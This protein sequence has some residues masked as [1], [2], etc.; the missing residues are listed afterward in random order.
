MG[1]SA[2]TGD[3]TDA[4]PLPGGSDSDD[5]SPP[6]SPPSDSDE[7]APDIEDLAD[8]NTIPPVSRSLAPGMLGDSFFTRGQILGMTPSSHGGFIDIPGSRRAKITENNSPL[9]RDR[10]YFMYQHF[11]NAIRGA[12]DFEEWVPEQNERQFDFSANR[13]VIG[14]EKTFFKGCCSAEIRIPLQDSTNFGVSPWP[15]PY[16]L[17]TARSDSGSLGNISLTFKGL[18]RQTNKGA[19][20]AG[21][22]VDLPT[23]PSASGATYWQPYELQ[24]DSVHLGPFL[25]AIYR[26]DDCW[27]FQGFMQLDVDVNGSPFEVTD[28]WTGAP[29]RMGVLQDQTLMHLDLS[30]GRWLVRR[31]RTSFLTGIAGLLEFHYTTTLQDADIVGTPVDSLPFVFNFYYMEVG[32]RYNRVDVTNLTAGLHFQFRKGLNMRI[33]AVTPLQNSES[34]RSFDFELGAQVNWVF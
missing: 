3:G 17:F 1:G 10:V 25:G 11:H 16:H 27:F 4:A 15:E 13:Y 14:L 8:L 6:V 30:A 21:L 32:N 28:L 33:A 2:V 19:L 31:P 12:E 5:T 7:I 26:P 20:S 23:G 9:P 29:M 22:M 34:D 24:N 18:L